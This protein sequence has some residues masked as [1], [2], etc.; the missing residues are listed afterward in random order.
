MKRSEF[1]KK[2][3]AVGLGIGA[4]AVIPTTSVEGGGKR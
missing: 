3:G 2:T 1:L 4:M